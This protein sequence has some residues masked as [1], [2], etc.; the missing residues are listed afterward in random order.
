MI[1]KNLIWNRIRSKILGF[2]IWICV[3][4]IPGTDP[5]RNTELAE[6][7]PYLS[8]RLD[9]VPE[10]KEEVAGDGGTFGEAAAALH[11]GRHT[12]HML[13]GHQL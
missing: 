10:E 2:L 13:Q 12:H 11:R 5:D 7:P 1:K 4:R 3:K 6:Q 9:A 8:D